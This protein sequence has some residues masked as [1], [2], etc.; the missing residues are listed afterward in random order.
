MSGEYHFTSDAHGKPAFVSALENATRKPGRDVA[1]PLDRIDTSA[2][3]NPG[4]GASPILFAEV[5]L[6]Y[7]HTGDEPIESDELGK[8]VLL[9]RVTAIG[10]TRLQEAV[11]TFH[12]M[13]IE[14]YRLG[15][16]LS[17]KERKGAMWF[18]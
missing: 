10:R 15:E 16:G 4:P 13:S 8:N 11:E 6:R 3:Y 2:Y 18:W 1:V 14:V 5:R 7:I 17:S 9:I 12:D